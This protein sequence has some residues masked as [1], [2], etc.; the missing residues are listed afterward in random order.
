[1]WN[2]ASEIYLRPNIGWIIININEFW[3]TLVGFKLE[4]IF[5]HT[6]IVLRLLCTIFILGFSVV[7]R[8]FSH[9]LWIGIT[10][11]SIMLQVRLKDLCLL[12]VAHEF[13]R[14]CDFANVIVTFLQRT[15][16]IRRLNQLNF[17]YLLFI[18]LRFNNNVYFLNFIFTFLF[19][20][21]QKQVDTAFC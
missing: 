3:N 20:L 8:S 9:F 7:V 10:L 14:K 5:S 19:I 12:S 6:F 18:I 17:I 21:I 15:N 4:A 2:F 16:L 1:M 11:H 13:A